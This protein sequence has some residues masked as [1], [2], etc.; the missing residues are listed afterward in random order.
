MP[1]TAQTSA[2]AAAAATARSVV[3]SSQP[4]SMI[5]VTPAARARS[6]RSSCPA[7][8][9]SWMWAW[10]STSTRLPARDRVDGCGQLEP[11]GIHEEEGEAAA[12]Q[13]VHVDEPADGIGKAQRALG[14]LDEQDARA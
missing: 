9:A 1:M 10:V 5:R 3:C 13:A 12:L 2:W 8:A 11:H 14:S 6:T 4:T 7:K